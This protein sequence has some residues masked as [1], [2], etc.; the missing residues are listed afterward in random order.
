MKKV[1]VITGGG[2]GIGKAAAEA[3]QRE[4]MTVCTADILPGCS[5]TGDVG[6]RED[7]EA[8]AREVITHYRRVDV[9]VNNAPPPMKGI[10]ECSYEDFQYALA[11]GVTAPFYLTRLFLPFFAPGASVINISS[12]KLMY[13]KI[14]NLIFPLC[15]F[16]L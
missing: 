2:H 16:L 9:L 15:C 6:K 7:L 13:F 1:A 5:F 8:F 10:D 12:S 11:V 14:H 3:F 4:G